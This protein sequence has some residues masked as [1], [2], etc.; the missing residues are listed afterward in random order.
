MKD[1]VEG[2]AWGFILGLLFIFASK[3][4]WD[5]GKSSVRIKGSKVLAINSAQSFVQGVGAQE[6]KQAG[7]EEGRL[8]RCGIS[9]RGAFLSEG[10]EGE[11][12]VGPGVC[13]RT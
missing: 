2:E 8:R 6:R 12:G 13:S 7:G 11:E 4:P 1:S 3:M 9:R 5:A 10:G